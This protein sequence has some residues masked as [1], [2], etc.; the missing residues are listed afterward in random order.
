[1]GLL[2]VEYLCLKLSKGITA[3]GGIEDSPLYVDVF[4]EPSPGSPVIGT[5]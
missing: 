1:M 2:S 4:K 3:G 5:L